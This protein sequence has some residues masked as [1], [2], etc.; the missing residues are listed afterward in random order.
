[1]FFTFGNCSSSNLFYD[2]NKTHHT[3]SGFI[4]P[5]PGFQDH[6]FLDLFRWMSTRFLN[7]T[8]L[9]PEDYE[10]ITYENDGKKL[11]N[12]NGRWSVTW[13]GHATTIVQ[14]EGMNVVTDP[15]WSERC[16]PVSWAGPKRYT[17][18]GV[19]IENLPKIDVVIISHNHYDHMDIPS[20][21]E[22]DR[23]FSPLFLVGLRNRQFL[24]DAGIQNVR[25]LDWWDEIDVLGKKI[26]F[27]PT[28]HF[29]ARGV[30]DRDETLWGSYAI[31]GKKTK[32]FFGGDTGYFPGFKEIGEKFEGFDLAILPIGAYNPKW[33]MEP[34]HMD[35]PQSV[36]AYI[37][38]KAKFLMPMH[39]NTFVLTDEPL[40][41]PVPYTKKELEKRS[42]SL[43]RLLDLKLGESFF[44]N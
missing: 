44:G 43:D 39:Y 5:T 17:K 3:K 11:L 21:L 37:D 6:G 22:L 29:S 34:V 26:V 41:E 10:F 40:D 13:I 38:L 28:Q 25:E 33:F 4:N 36:Q 1:M 32:V 8:S 27:T 2:P 16:S 35:P 18:P 24:I 20:L 14:I 12:Y 31:I 42:I 15:I 19:A 9:D 7:E 23:K 30:F